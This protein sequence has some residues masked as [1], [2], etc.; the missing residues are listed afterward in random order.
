MDNE[1][2]KVLN[3]GSSSQPKGN[4]SE[5]KTTTDSKKSDRLAK[6][7]YAAG[8]FV[9]GVAST[10]TIDAFGSTE[11]VPEEVIATEEV[12]EETNSQEIPQEPEE[13]VQTVDD[14]QTA[15]DS[16]PY[17]TTD[18]GMRVAQVD[19]DMSFSKAFAEARAQ[20]GAGGAFEWHGRVYGTYYQTEWN[21]M[22]HAERAEFE[23]KV[24]YQEILSHNNDVVKTDIDTSV[25]NSHSDHNDMVHET[26]YEDAE[27]HAVEYVDD[28]YDND[29]IMVVGAGE[30]EMADGTHNGAVLAYG[31][32]QALIVDVDDD[33][34]FDVLIH[35]DNGDGQISFDEY[36]EIPDGG[37]T[38][39]DINAHI[40]AQN[41]PNGLVAYDDDM[42]DYMNDA[43]AGLYDA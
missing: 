23:S 1:E 3:L 5:N 19:D 42:P 2:T 30:I 37:V 8:G 26:S 17:Y 12:P 16:V 39:D 40:E 31:D 18:E 35:D 15:D 10:V 7:A 24:D 32:D 33:G 34:D 14:G 20:V 11:E 43:D 22:S 9:A 27:P 21:Q 25:S 38:Y 13:V 29:D 41:N 4:K 36:H 28:S 6:A